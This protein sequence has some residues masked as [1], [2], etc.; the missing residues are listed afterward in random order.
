M[1]LGTLMILSNVAAQD[2]VEFNRWYDREH[3]RERVAIPGFLSARRYISTRNC[4][5]KY[6]A[7]YDTEDSKT[8]RSPAYS[9]ALANQSS[10][11]KAVLGK[12]RDP[13]RCVAERTLSIGCGSGALLSLTCLRPRAGRADDLRRILSDSLFPRLHA[14]DAVVQVSL[15]E[16]DGLQS[17]PIPEY[18]PSRISLVRPDDWFIALDAMAAGAARLRFPRDVRTT[19]TEAV[20]PLGTFRLLWD[21]HRS[22]IE[23]RSRR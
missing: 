14:K 10:W 17:R 6:L 9:Q 22:D 2:E 7:I 19:M 3:M 16:C 21:L 18:P 1:G 12:F 13:Q 8:F 23:L 11:S 20:E 5:W 4:P 15:L